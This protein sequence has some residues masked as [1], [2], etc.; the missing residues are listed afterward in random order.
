MGIL[1][2]PKE[3]NRLA[4]SAILHP[5]MVALACATLM[6]AWSF[7]LFSDWRES[8]VS[9]IIMAVVI[10]FLWRRGGPARRR[11]ERLFPPEPPDN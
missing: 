7:V 6:G 11:E 2:R 4:R 10:W 5:C 8:L 1:K 3:Q 9:G